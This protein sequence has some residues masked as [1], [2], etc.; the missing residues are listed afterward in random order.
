M[1][2]T[3]KRFWVWAMGMCALQGTLSAQL[4]LETCYRAAR[5]NYPL[6]RQFDLIERTKDFTVENATKVIFPN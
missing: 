4:T 5:E 3:M 2:K 1:I 6:V